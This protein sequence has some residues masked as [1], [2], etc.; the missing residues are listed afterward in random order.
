MLDAFRREL[1][2]LDKAIKAKEA[3]IAQ[4]NARS[5]ELGHEGESI[6]REV[7]SAQSAVAKLEQKWEWI[8][9]ER[10]S[11]LPLAFAPGG[12]EGLKRKGTGTLASRGPTLISRGRG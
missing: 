5:V 12:V 8:P 1:G 4:A 3:E 7:K 10:K 11:V 9:G 2:E 6:E